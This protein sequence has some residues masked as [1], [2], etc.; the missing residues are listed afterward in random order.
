MA[1]VFYDCDPN[2][3]PGGT[4]ARLQAAGYDAW[5]SGRRRIRLR[6]LEAAGG[7]TPP[8]YVLSAWA[9]ANV[10]SHAGF[11]GS[12]RASASPAQP[13][14]PLNF[15]NVVQT[16][17]AR[18]RFA[19]ASRL[20]FFEEAASH[21]I[22][23][24]SRDAAQILDI[25]VLPEFF[26][27]WPGGQVA[28][29]DVDPAWG[30]RA[31]ALRALASADTMSWDWV[32]RVPGRPFVGFPMLRAYHAGPSVNFDRLLTSFFAVTAPNNRVVSVTRGPG[33][34]VFVLDQPAD[35]FA[36]LQPHAAT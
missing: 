8:C 14:V 25:F 3:V 18:Q 12:V 21:L 19:A 27:R 1:G 13:Y 11:L 36:N 17:N 15:A 26:R 10:A 4:I 29:V 24:S 35:P 7:R 2:Q 23:T 31:G 34:V 6:S 9:T 33:W 22:T 16:G 30:E 5:L 28:F 20:S 32:R